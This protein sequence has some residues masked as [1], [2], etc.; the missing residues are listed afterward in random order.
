MTVD[1]AGPLLVALVLVVGIQAA[2][3]W[4]L[5]VG[6]MAWS[7]AVQL[8]AALSARKA[9]E[10]QAAPP[11]YVPDEATRHAPGAPPGW[12]PAPVDVFAEKPS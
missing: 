12:S 11:A 1:L 4:R 6:V 9:R 7:E 5:V 10:A 2:L 8:D 3:V